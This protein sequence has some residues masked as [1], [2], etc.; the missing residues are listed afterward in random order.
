MNRQKVLLEVN[1]SRG[2]YELSQQEKFTIGLI[3]KKISKYL[4]SDA[5]TSDQKIKFDDLESKIKTGPFEKSKFEY[6][7][8]QKIPVSGMLHQTYRLTV[9]R[10][11][12]L[13]GLEWTDDDILISVKAE[14]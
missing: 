9:N 4:A 13:I 14:K 1:K 12:F 6:I 11:S 10:K 3:R 7:K 2:E 8:S 5:D